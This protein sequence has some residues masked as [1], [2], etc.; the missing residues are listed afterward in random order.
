[1]AGEVLVIEDI[2]TMD[3]LACNIANFWQ[4]WDSLRT[5]W[6]TQT[7]E[8]HRFLFAT[9]TTQTSVAK[10]PWKNKTTLPKLCQIRDNLYANYTATLFPQRK[11]VIWE[12]G[13]PES[14]YT[15]K[16]DAIENYMQWVLSQPNFKREM[17]KLI[18]DY[19]DYGN[20]FATIDWCDERIELADKTQVGYVGPALRRINPFDI[21][22][23]PIAESFE[24]SPKIIRT[25]M[26][27]GELK[28]MLERMSV[29]DNT[30]D[31]K[32]IYNYLKDIRSSVANFQGDRTN[33]DSIF[34]ISGFSSFGNYLDSDFVEILTFYGDIYSREDDK[35]YE[36]H[37]ITVVDRHKIISKKPNPSFFGQPP[38][39]HIGWRRRQDNLWAMGPLDN[40]VGMQYRIDHL[41]NLKADV[42]DLT[43]FPVQKIKGSGVEEYEWGPNERIVMDSDSDVEMERPDA[44]ALQA[45]VDIEYLLSKMEEMA[46]APKEAVGFRTPGEKT[47]YEVQR[48][49]NASSRVYQNKINQFSDFVEKCLNGLLELGRRNTGSAFTIAI[50]D[51]EFDIQTFQQLTVTDIT[52]VGRIRP[53]AARHFAEQAELVQNLTSLAG[54]GLMP[55]V[56][57]H[58]SG[59]A[60]AKTFDY[61]FNTK[62]FGIFVPF[63]GITEQ[64]EAQKIASISQENAMTSAATPSGLT[65]DDYNAS[66]VGQ[67]PQ[68]ADQESSVPTGS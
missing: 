27:M 28:K 46:G 25:L 59:V 64:A 47:K 51:D 8:T 61:M 44:G 56:Q 50:T 40:L 45:N 11:W 36:N 26:S 52:G 34:N 4:Q 35:F 5:Q 30:E 55:I 58:M 10:L 38:I 66:S 42:W 13:S 48:L 23:N 17:D 2:L 15:A 43:A 24:R 54:S 9:D 67:A 41:E 37:I 63:I 57:P 21:V 32:K 53:I 16:R 12:A 20:C 1:M 3:N 31:Y 39:W 14:A 60:T 65:P 49:E 19:I 22:F 6:K 29:D 7:D 18:L 62:D 68:G 33:R